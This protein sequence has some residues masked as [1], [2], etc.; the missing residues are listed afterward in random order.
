MRVI[1]ILYEVCDL[2]RPHQEPGSDVV[3]GYN[4]CVGQVSRLI[5]SCQPGIF[6]FNLLSPA[7]FRNDAIENPSMCQI[8]NTALKGL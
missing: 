5:T 8:S 3:F 2:A 7:W 6:G 1:V 4:N